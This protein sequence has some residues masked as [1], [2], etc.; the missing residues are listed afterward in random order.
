MTLEEEVQALRDRL[1]KLLRQLADAS[2][3][4]IDE[5]KR[6]QIEVVVIRALLRLLCEDTHLLTIDAN[7]R[8]ITHRL[9]IYLQ[10]LLPA[11]HVDCEYNRKFD[12]PKRLDLTPDGT[13]KV[14]DTNGTT[15]FPDIIVHRRNT[16]VNLLVIEV[17][18]TTSTRKDT[19]DLQ[20]LRGF[21][22]SECYRYCYAL[23]LK[24]KT[25]NG[26]VGIEPLEWIE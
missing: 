4:C 20:K 5:P 19:K 23:F 26:C 24:L 14:N 13:A 2:V 10:D 6:P 9:A 3:Q 1:G 21:L 22:E 25:G 8:S 16:G 7:E 17:K 15:V 18:K 12:A 11:W